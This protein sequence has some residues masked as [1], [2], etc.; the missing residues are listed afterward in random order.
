M[1]YRF[2]VSMTCTGYGIVEAD[3]IDE[4]KVKIFNN[5][6]EDIY[7]HEDFQVLGLIELEEDEANEEMDEEIEE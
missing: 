3:S 6:Y 5:E 7:E 2:T 1:V 4:A